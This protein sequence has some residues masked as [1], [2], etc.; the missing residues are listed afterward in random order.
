MSTKT[1]Q[2]AP[3]PELLDSL[4]GETTVC[5]RVF[6]VFEFGGNL[7]RSFMS[8]FTSIVRINGN[9]F[10][11]IPISEILPE[12]VLQYRNNANTGAFGDYICEHA[13][14]IYDCGNGIVLLDLSYK[15]VL[16]EEEYLDES[17][18][19][20]ELVW[21][22]DFKTRT[23]V[24]IGDDKES[25]AFIMKARQELL[26][27]CKKRKEFIVGR[28]FPKKEDFKKHF[29]TGY[30][31]FIVP[32]TEE[33]L[34]NFYTDKYGNILNYG[35]CAV[36]NKSVKANIDTKYRSYLNIYSKDGEKLHTVKFHGIP[37]HI[38][39]I[40]DWY[41]VCCQR[42]ATSKKAPMLSLY[43]FKLS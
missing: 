19:Q 18:V 1:K 22:V 8:M 41:Y 12:D 24:P 20:S 32:D 38:E 9:H 26:N 40:G 17:T 3:K 2:N 34:S 36:Y 37:I 10:E 7:N 31:N 29:K 42:K 35:N 11:Q 6:G 21:K 23:S 14:C 33:S 39:E 13:P 15:K 4:E 16:K 25:V 27:R 30:G 28:C 5:D 43:R